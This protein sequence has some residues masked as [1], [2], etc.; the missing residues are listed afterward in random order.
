MTCRWPAREPCVRNLEPGAQGSQSQGDVGRNLLPPILRS[1]PGQWD[2]RSC[3]EKEYS[4][5]TREGKPRNGIGQCSNV[6]QRLPEKTWKHKWCKYQP[7]DRVITAGHWRM[8]GEKKEESSVSH[9][10]GKGWYVPANG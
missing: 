10:S 8:A 9:E 4:R 1:K 7:F 2:A 3:V 5:V 6:S